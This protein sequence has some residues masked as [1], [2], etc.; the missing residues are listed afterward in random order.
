MIKKN[1]K[2]YLSSLC[3]M[4]TR[5]RFQMHN[6]GKNGAALIIYIQPYRYLPQG[7]RGDRRGWFGFQDNGQGPRKNKDTKENPWGKTILKRRATNTNH[8]G[9][10]TG[11]KKA[12]QEY[13]DTTRHQSTGQTFRTVRTRKKGRKCEA[14]HGTWRSTRQITVHVTPMECYTH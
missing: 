4:T 14:R 12:T 6:E 1:Q 10:L 9:T 8:K 11:W 13:N 2:Y 3:Y 5:I 7:L